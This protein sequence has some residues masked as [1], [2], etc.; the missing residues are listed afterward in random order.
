MSETENLDLPLISR[1]RSSRKNIGSMDG[2]RSSGESLETPIETLMDHSSS[3]PDSLSRMSSDN[4]SSSPPVIDDLEDTSMNL[5]GLSDFADF[6][7]TLLCQTTEDSTQANAVT[8]S[9][10]DNDFIEQDSTEDS[11][12]AN[13]VIL[14]TIDNDFIEQD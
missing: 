11:T 7:D 5:S 13:A 14:S 3:V 12:Q 2:S 6:L 9:T 1:T 8:L 4:S 10:I